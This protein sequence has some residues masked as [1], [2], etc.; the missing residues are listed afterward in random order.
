VASFVNNKYGDVTIE[1]IP[2]L[3][4]HTWQLN[5]SLLLKKG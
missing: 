4:S 3:M 1:S 2:Q 5:T